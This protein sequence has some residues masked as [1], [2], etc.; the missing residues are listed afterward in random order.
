VLE[1][2]RLMLRRFTPDDV[3]NLVEL[4]GDPEVMRLY[5]RGPR[6]AARAD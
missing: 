5:Q 6:D 2:E 4:N 1:T 3:E